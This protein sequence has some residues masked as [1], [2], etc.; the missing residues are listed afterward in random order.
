MLRRINVMWTTSLQEHLESSQLMA[1]RRWEGSRSFHHYM[2]TMKM[3]TNSW[4]M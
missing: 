3:D 2:R 1:A 4:M